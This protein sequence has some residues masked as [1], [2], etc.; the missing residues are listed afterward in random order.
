MAA[1]TTGA[2]H[3]QFQLLGRCLLLKFTHEF[4][5]TISALLAVISVVKEIV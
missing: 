4:E 3:L 1:P 2:S 5:T